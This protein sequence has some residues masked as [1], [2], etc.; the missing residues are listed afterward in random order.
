MADDFFQEDQQGESQK[1]KVGEKEYTQDELNTLVGLGQIAQEVET[2]YNTKIDRVYP[3][4]TK[5]QQ[6][7]KTYESEIETLRKEKE[8]S[9]HHMD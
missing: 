3:E 7:L 8:S 2:R 6:K 5:S 9:K 1:I 4:F